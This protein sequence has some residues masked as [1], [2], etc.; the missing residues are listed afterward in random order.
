[1]A[2]QIFQFFQQITIP[3]SYRNKFKIWLLNLQLSMQIWVYFNKACHLKV[4]YPYPNR[5]P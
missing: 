2:I 1:M 5:Y 4:Q 3:S